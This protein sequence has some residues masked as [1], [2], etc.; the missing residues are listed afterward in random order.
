MEEKKCMRKK[1][2][3]ITERS[4]LLKNILNIEDCVIFLFLTCS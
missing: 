1:D 2:T 4:T 3:R